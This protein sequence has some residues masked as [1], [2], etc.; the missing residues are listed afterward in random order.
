M[1]VRQQVNRDDSQAEHGRL[2][3]VEGRVVQQS[4]HNLGRDHPVLRRDLADVEFLEVRRFRQ[5]VRVEEFILV[6]REEQ[7]LAAREGAVVD[8]LVVLDEQPVHD[9]VEEGVHVG[10][11]GDAVGRELQRGVNRLVVGAELVL[12][13]HVNLEDADDEGRVVALSLVQLFDEPLGLRFGLDEGPLAEIG[14]ELA[15]LDPAVEGVVDAGRRVGL[16]RHLGL[17]H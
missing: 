14:V 1:H 7:D 6:V 13:L 17:S 5:D 8:A 3:V 15:E 2:L 16:R 4:P 12:L 10:D 9:L 11:L